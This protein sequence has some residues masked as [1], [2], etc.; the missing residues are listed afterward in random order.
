MVGRRCGGDE[1]CRGDVT[2]GLF[3]FWRGAGECPRHTA[4]RHTAT[5]PHNEMRGRRVSRLG[6]K[7]TP[8][9]DMTVS[10]QHLLSKAAQDGL[11]VARLRADRNVRATQELLPSIPKEGVN[12]T[13]GEMQIP[14]RCAVRDD[15][16]Q[17][18]LCY[19]HRGRDG[20]LA[21]S[22]PTQAKR[23]LEWATRLPLGCCGCFP[24]LRKRKRRMGHPRGSGNPPGLQSFTPLCQPI[25]TSPFNVDRR[26]RSD[27]RS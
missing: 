20:T 10:R 7:D 15:N 12:G 8:S 2:Q 3:S 13:S 9:L 22:C 27:G 19:D 26:R 11:L 23:R 14:R 17:D 25:Y 16:N 5:Q 24:S 18:C 6:R 21:S 1:A 4:T